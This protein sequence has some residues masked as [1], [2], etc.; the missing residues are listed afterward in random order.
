[1]RHAQAVRQLARA[2]HRL[3]RAA[4][5]L[6]VVLG[7][8]PQFERH[9]DGLLASLRHEQRGHRAVDAAAHR[10]ER[11]SRRRREHRALAR[12][13]SQRPVQRVGRE[14]GRVALCEAQ[15]AELLGDLLGADARRVQQRGPRSSPTA[16]LPAAIVLPQPLASKPASRD[17]PLGAGGVER[18]RHAHQIAARR[19]AGGARE[20]VRRTVT[21]PQRSAQVLRELLSG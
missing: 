13:G 2:P 11:P 15:P 1:M 8:R 12:G 5:E 17:P 19:S 10:N 3:R 14:L 20:G 9:A 18:D 21:A 6:A 4:A 7:V 16:A